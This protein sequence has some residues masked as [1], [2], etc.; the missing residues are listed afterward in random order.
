L[1]NLDVLDLHNTQVSGVVGAA[2]DSHGY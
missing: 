1:V 2:G